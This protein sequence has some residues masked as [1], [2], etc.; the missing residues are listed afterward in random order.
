MY[1]ITVGITM[2]R[3]ATIA[4]VDQIKT[5]NRQHS[6]NYPFMPFH[7][8]VVPFVWFLL[9]PPSTLILHIQTKLCNSLVCY[10]CSIFYAHY[11]KFP[12]MLQFYRPK[13]R[14]NKTTD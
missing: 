13:T 9:M 6:Q 10:F 11:Q 4:K 5:Q 3:H 8:R 7:F 2:G 12:R 1:A 14:M